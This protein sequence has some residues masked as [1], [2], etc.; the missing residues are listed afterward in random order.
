MVGAG[1][2]EPDGAEAAEAVEATEL[3]A[4]GVRRREPRLCATR[5]GEPSADDPDESNEPHDGDSEEELD[6]DAAPQCG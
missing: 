2:G 5:R 3:G 4:S 1:S 6:V